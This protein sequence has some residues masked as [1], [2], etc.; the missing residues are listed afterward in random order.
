MNYLLILPPLLLIPPLIIASLPLIVIDDIKVAMPMPTLTHTL[1][2][3][4]LSLQ[5]TLR[6]NTSG[7]IM[8]KRFAQLA[9]R[10]RSM[11]L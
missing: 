10:T 8:M 4:N 7:S 6:K 3:I 1:M 9:A 11:G 5:P 2:L